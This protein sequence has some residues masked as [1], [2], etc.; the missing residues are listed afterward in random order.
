MR[1][2]A[3]PSRRRLACWYSSESYQRR[4]AA[5]SSNSRMTRRGGCQS[6][7]R[8][9]SPPAPATQGPAAGGGDRVGRG[10]LVVLV[11]LG[12]GDV[13]LDDDVSGH[14]RESTLAVA[15][16]ATGSGGD[17]VLNGIDLYACTASSGGPSA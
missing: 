16:P 10:G 17:R 3:A 13:G 8:T 7:S 4:A 1:R 14:G 15:V 5:R 9:A 2:C 6:P 12:V 11:L